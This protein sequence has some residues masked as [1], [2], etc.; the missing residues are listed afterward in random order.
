MYVWS[1]LF[2]NKPDFY[3]VTCISYSLIYCTD[4]FSDKKNT[5]ASITISDSHMANSTFKCSKK[6]RIFAWCH[7]KIVFHL[8]R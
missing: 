2:D 6:L 8:E 1:L 3:F 5:T 4:A 7:Q